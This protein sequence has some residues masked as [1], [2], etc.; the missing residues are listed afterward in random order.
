M[1]AQRSSENS[2]CIRLFAAVLALALCITPVPRVEAQGKFPERPITLICPYGAGGGTDLFARGIQPFMS[3]YLGV[4]VIVENIPGGTGIIGTTKLYNAKPDG[5]TISTSNLPDIMS[6]KIMF[7]PSYEPERFTP[8]A[9]WAN[10]PLLLGA[11]ETFQNF[12]QF[13]ETAAKRKVSIG[14]AGGIGTT[15]WIVNLALEKDTGI[16]FNKVPYAESGQVATAVAGKHLDAMIIVSSAIV[17]FVK[18][19]QIKPLVVF[20]DQRDP[21]Y[22]EVPTIRELGYKFPV[23]AIRRGVIGPPHI[24]GDR[25][26]ILEAA[27][28]KAVNDP[29]YLDMCKKMN[30]IVN[31]LPSEVY[32]KQIREET[33]FLD[34]FSDL[35]KKK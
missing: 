6:A 4:Q 8:I 19:G 5:Y 32:G 18:A 14:Q 30:I 24:P 35:L 13:M 7:N 34:Q 26:K 25:V 2:S 15:A 33:H 10:M 28:F 31:F 27:L 11:N 20:Y 17:S 22:P 9:G 12:K 21:L 23:F 29:E 1:P 3:R 16:E